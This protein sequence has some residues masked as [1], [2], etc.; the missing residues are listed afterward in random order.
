MNPVEKAEKMTS[1]T[2]SDE[3]PKEEV[4]IS[5]EPITGE[6]CDHCHLA[7]HGD[8]RAIHKYGK[9]FHNKPCWREV[10]KIATIKGFQG[11]I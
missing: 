4:V 5:Q 1:E 8:Q 6:Y 3:E 11:K 7:I 2:S 9:T 10:Q